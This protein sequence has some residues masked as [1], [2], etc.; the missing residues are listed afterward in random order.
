[1]VFG[2]ATRY[3]RLMSSRVRLVV[4]PLILFFGV[5]GL[6]YGLAKAHPARPD[7][8]AASGPGGAKIKVGD[9]YRGATVFQQS[10]ASCH[11]DDGAGGGIGPKLA[12][13]GITV[14]EAKAQIDHGGGVMTAGIVSGKAEE[15]VLAYL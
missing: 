3:D 4:I 7:V 5:S 9:P 12:Q 15:D 11:G 10:C 2:D 6:V 13:S 14:D 1:M 8:K